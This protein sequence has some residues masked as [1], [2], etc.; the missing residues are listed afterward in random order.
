MMVSSN[1]PILFPRSHPLGVRVGVPK[2]ELRLDLSSSSTFSKF[3]ELSDSVISSS[4]I[5]NLI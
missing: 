5:S 3:I 1:S 2:G 4:F